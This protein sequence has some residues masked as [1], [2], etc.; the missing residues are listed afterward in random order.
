MLGLKE[1]EL[2]KDESKKLAD[3]IQ[4]VGKYYNIGFDPKK[5]AIAQLCIVAG[6][7]YGPMF[8]QIRR[9]MKSQRVPQPTPIATPID[10]QPKQAPQ[11]PARPMSEMSPSDL[12]GNES[13]VI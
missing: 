7:I 1:L 9:R 3:A 6:G 11:Q 10:R 4:D 8:V 5:V 12:F 13:A 2:E